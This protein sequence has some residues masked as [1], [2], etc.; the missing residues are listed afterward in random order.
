MGEPPMPPRYAAGLASGAGRSY[1]WDGGGP[2]HRGGG[3]ISFSREMLP[4]W[5]IREE[6]LGS[7][8]RS[9]RLVLSAPTGSGKT[10]QVPQ[11]LLRGGRADEKRQ[12][13]VLQPRRLAARLVAQ[14]VAA[15]LGVG[16]GDVVGYQTRHESRVGPRTAIRFMTEGLFL[17]ILQS[18]PKLEGIGTVIL[19]E[20]HERN[21]ATDV[22]L[23]LVKVLQETRRADLR[24]IVMSATLDTQKVAGYLECPALEAH[25]RMWPVDV[26]YMARRRAAAR[27]GTYDNR[28]ATPVWELAGDALAEVLEAS[29][30]GD[31][32]IFMPGG[33][34]IR[35]TIE[36][37]RRVAGDG[38]A[39]FPLYSELPAEEQDM[40]LRRRRDGR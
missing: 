40:A 17:R 11:F 16:I 14:R 6:I 13:I 2:D 28:R 29:G 22:A 38:V 15:E 26:R 12:V 5:D 23:A 34:E 37:C 25:G 1:G 18:N 32:L 10:T 3:V 4:I 24:M 31:V 20:F 8:A 36:E 33:Y 7:L 21:L 39:V 9:N 30:E 35:R 27:V 19:D